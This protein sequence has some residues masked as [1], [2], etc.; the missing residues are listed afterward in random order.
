MH[1][2]DEMAADS[3]AEDGT[4]EVDNDGERRHACD[5]RVGSNFTRFVGGTLESDGTGEEVDGERGR[6]AVSSVEEY[7]CLNYKSMTFKVV[8]GYASLLHVYILSLTACNFV[9]NVLHSCD[10]T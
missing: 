1:V 9:C 4:S 3:G 8:R 10:A 6:M 5:V 2:G 7:S